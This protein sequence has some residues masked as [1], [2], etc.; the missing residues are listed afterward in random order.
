[1]I[2]IHYFKTYYYIIVDEIL[3]TTFYTYARLGSVRLY[4]HGTEHIFI[5]A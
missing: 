5:Y 2:Y 4:V 3:S 1:M